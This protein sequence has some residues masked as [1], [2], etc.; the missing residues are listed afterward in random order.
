MINSYPP[1]L[2]LAAT[3]FKGND[4]HFED[5][6][7]PSNDVWAKRRQNRLSSEVSHF[8]GGQFLAPKSLRRHSR[9]SSIDIGTCIALHPPVEDC[10]LGEH[11]NA[12][13]TKLQ[14]LPPVGPPMFMMFEHQ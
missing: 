12:S 7:T 5:R 2:S 4:A 6:V 9:L 10:L 13:S 14:G 8:A 1:F 11:N 3:P